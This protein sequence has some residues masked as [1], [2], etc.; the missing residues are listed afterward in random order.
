MRLSIQAVLGFFGALLSGR[1]W[2]RYL[3]F[4]RG[5]G[6]EVCLVSVSRA[7]AER[8]D[9]SGGEASGSRESEEGMPRK[10]AISR[11]RARRWPSLKFKVVK[12]FA[13]VGG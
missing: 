9:C 8:D 12:S 3:L 6:V 5:G 13:Y 7:E 10:V 4:S 2:R 11:C 1:G